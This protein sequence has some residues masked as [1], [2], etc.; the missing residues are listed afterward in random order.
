M[1]DLVRCAG[2]GMQARPPPQN[3][4]TEVKVETGIVF[5][6]V[7]VELPGPKSA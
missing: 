4:G 2:C 1:V 6:S 7:N 3:G 5:V